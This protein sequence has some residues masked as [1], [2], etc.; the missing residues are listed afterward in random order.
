[1]INKKTKEEDL[2][3]IVK[4]LDI[5]PTMYKNATEKYKSLADTIIAYGLDV[6][7]YPQGSFSLGTVVKPYSQNEDSVYDLDFICKL[8]GVSK[9]NTNPKNVKFQVKDAICSNKIYAER[10]QREYDKCWTLEY[11]KVSGCYF[12]MDIVPAV[13]EEEIK[14]LNIL[15]S[16]QY[17]IAITN[18]ENSQ[19]YSWCTINPKA[20]VEWFQ[21][22]NK[23]FN[24]YNREIRLK[25]ILN[26]NLA[27]FN[28]VEEIPPM[29]E[30]SSLQRVIQILKRHRDVYF[31]KVRRE[32]LKPVSVILTT[33]VAQIAQSAP[34]NYSV[35]ELLEYTV[36][37]LTSLLEGLKFN[38]N[39]ALKDNNKWILL[40]P[41]NSLDNLVD[42]WNE[43]I[44]KPK[45][46][47]RWMKCLRGDFLTDI[48][49]DKKYEILLENSFGYTAVNKFVDL[50][51]NEIKEPEMIINMAKPWRL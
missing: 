45:W 49:D 22:I 21:S 1:M 37:A 50:N 32:D 15:N 44:E 3:K 4:G 30:R 34:A 2:I 13:K 24:D 42:S 9:N 10:L 5:T 27:F 33:L 18:K 17:S 7:I 6:E 46:F 31:N 48:L 16:P 40:N 14:I 43:N 25:N 51:K 36:K 23:K 39:F 20:Y 29:L 47:L 28:S 26:E 8:N 12:N 19:L 35:Y 11:A 38:Q 41:V